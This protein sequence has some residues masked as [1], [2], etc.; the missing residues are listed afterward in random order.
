MYLVECPEQ[1]S[2][3]SPV[4][5]MLWQQSHGLGKMGNVVTSCGIIASFRLDMPKGDMY[6]VA[7][8]DEGWQ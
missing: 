7:A 6:L 3:M 1:M 8:S 2:R 5:L 4:T